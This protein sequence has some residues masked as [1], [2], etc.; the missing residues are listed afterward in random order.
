MI[1]PDGTSAWVTSKKDNIKRGTLRS[2]ANLNHQNTV[3]AISSRI[4]LQTNTETFGSRIDHDNAGFASAAA[5][6][7]YG[8][9]LFVALETS[10]EV[11]VINAHTHSEIFRIN[12]GRAPQAL[13]VSADGLRLF[14]S[15]FM[16]R[17][18]GVYDL[19]KV[20]NEGLSQA[21]LLATCSRSRSNGWPAT[22][23]S[24]SSSSTT[25]G[26]RVSAERAT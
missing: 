18:V 3:R 21:P 13:A 23:S 24:A 10:R 2:G 9:L 7:R 11:A 14:V 4:D 20:V 5:F 1:S 19:S 6:E 8:V 26:T 17:S 16:D 12:V 22:C 25:L 15:N